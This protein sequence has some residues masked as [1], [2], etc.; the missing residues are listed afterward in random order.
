MASNIKE[1]PFQTTSARDELIVHLSPSELS[2]S[3]LPESLLLAHP[4]HMNSRTVS[5]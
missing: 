3:I 4:V 2:S 5:D 1:L